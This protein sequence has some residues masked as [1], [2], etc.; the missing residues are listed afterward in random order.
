MYIVLSDNGE[1]MDE[2]MLKPDNASGGNNSPESGKSVDTTLQ[3]LKDHGISMLDDTDSTLLN[4]ALQS[5]RKLVLSDA[6]KMILN[7][8]KFRKNIPVVRSQPQQQQSS[9]N[10]PPPPLTFNMTSNLSNTMNLEQLRKQKPPMVLQPA[11]TA[12]SQSAGVKGLPLKTNKVIKILS[13]EE[14]KQM[15][16]ANA[17]G[18]TLKKISA[19]SFHNG[20]LK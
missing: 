16:G 3:I 9:P 19:E 17:S 11:A 14:F 12:S 2:P 20:Q 10:P 7:D 5:G 15:C 4:S 13:A 18:N 6:G 8:P 1:Q